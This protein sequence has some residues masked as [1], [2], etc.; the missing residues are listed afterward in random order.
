[1][2]DQHPKLT[3][4]NIASLERALLSRLDHALAYRQVITES[5]ESIAWLDCDFS[6]A[7]FQSA[8]LN[9]AIAEF[10]KRAPR[11]KIRLLMKDEVFL[12]TKAPRFMTL[13]RRYGHQ[14][15]AR[16]F[17]ETDWQGQCCLV[18]DTRHII[19]RMQHQEWRGSLALDA[20]ASAEQWALRFDQLWE[21]A[22]P[23]LA[24][25]TLGL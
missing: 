18:S 14:I 2:N 21:G 9:D 11:G 13:K 15:S 10:I 20:V 1:M 25:T 16:M 7:G 6:E 4:P 5:C 3:P 8:A 12:F 24:E 17:Q 19:T 23:C 22:S